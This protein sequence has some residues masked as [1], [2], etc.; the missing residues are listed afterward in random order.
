MF[1]KV[2]AQG[3]DA[4]AG[5]GIAFG[6]GQDGKA[7]GQADR[8]QLFRQSLAQVYRQELLMEG[9]AAVLAYLGGI[10]R[11]VGLGHK[12][13]VSDDVAYRTVAFEE[14]LGTDEGL[15]DGKQALA[16]ETAHQGLGIGKE[17]AIQSP[18]LQ[19]LF[20]F[21]DVV[22]TEIE[23]TIGKGFFKAAQPQGFDVFLHGNAQVEAFPPFQAQ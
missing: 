22:K 4:Q 21:F 19:A 18:V 10:G 9:V 5:I 16:G 6:H 8:Q 17:E 3:D 2:V 7:L 23:L 20:Q 14:G 12:V 1:C 13:A 15:A 11:A